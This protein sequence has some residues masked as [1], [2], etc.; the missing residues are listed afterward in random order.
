M[1]EDKIIPYIEPI[2]L[3]CRRRLENTY[4]AEDLAG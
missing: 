3:F 1:N 4:D 2:Y